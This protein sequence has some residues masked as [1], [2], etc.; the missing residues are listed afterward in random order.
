T[1]S[2][3]PLPRA[4]SERE[5]S[6]EAEIGGGV[7]AAGEILLKPIRDSMSQLSLFRGRRSAPELVAATLGNDAGLIGV[8]SLTRH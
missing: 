4:K 5:R 3:V 6:G 8:A 2:T 7:I 1:P